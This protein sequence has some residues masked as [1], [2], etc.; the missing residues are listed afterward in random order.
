MIEVGFMREEIVVPSINR[1]KNEPNNISLAASAIWSLDA[2][3]NHVALYLSTTTDNIYDVEKNFH[4]ILINSEYPNSFIFRVLHE[5]SNA[6]KHGRRHNQST[7]VSNSGLVSRNVKRENIVSY[8]AGDNYY[9]FQVVVELNIH[10][11]KE[12]KC[13]LFN[14]K[15]VGTYWPLF[16]EVPVFDILSPSLYLI[17][18]ALSTGTS[19]AFV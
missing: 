3:A 12:M 13:W 4:K 5:T 18:N 6:L 11:D 8:F 16:N 1:F 17:D 9:G 10:Y 2:Y 7:L 14:G 15:N 19:S